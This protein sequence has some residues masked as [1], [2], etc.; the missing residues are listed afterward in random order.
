M[1]E[2]HFL[3]LVITLCVIK[4]TFRKQKEAPKRTYKAPEGTSR[5]YSRKQA[6]EGLYFG[7]EPTPEEKAQQQQFIFE[8]LYRNTCPAS[9]IRKAFPHLA[10][11][12]DSLKKY[13]ALE[14]LYQEGQIDEITYNLE[15]NRILEGVNLQGDF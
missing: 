9:E 5:P 4:I 10:A 8:Y 15:L 3:L 2:V 1:N 13:E 7:P 11:Q 6:P 14:A 12:A